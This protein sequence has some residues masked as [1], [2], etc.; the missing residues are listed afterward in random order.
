M[1]Y[2][3]ARQSIR[4]AYGSRGQFG[5]EME[6]LEQVPTVWDDVAVLAAEPGDCVVLA[7]RSGPRWFLG[8]MNDEDPRRVRLPL[9]FLAQ[10]T[11]YR[12]TIFTD[13]PG[14]RDAQ[15]AVEQVTATSVLKVGLEPRGGLAAI[16]EPIS[17]P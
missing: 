8:G 11:P 3:G 13:V 15:R 6:F 5:A 9:G 17:A 10:G 14:A 2:H 16:I 7:R 12:A 4:R 1:V